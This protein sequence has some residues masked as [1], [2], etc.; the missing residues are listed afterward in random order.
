MSSHNRE[1][2]EYDEQA[3]ADMANRAYENIVKCF[4]KG[5]DAASLL[6]SND[7]TSSQLRGVLF[8]R[9]RGETATVNDLITCRI[10]NDIVKINEKILVDI[11]SFLIMNNAQ[12]IDNMCLVVQSILQ[13]FTDSDRAKFS[14]GKNEINRRVIK[15]FDV[16]R[17]INSP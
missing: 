9:S 5:N 11:P 6:F 4:R 14:R 8:G 17:E 1:S 10:Q 15:F 7:E 2:N 13:G 12:I 16:E 3:K